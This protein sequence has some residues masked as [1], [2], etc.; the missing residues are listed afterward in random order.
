MVDSLQNYSLL[1]KKQ[2]KTKQKDKKLVVSHVSCFSF[3]SRPGFS[4]RMLLLNE[5]EVS[6]SCLLSNLFRPPAF[7]LEKREATVKKQ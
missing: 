2:N 5:Q 6:T 7:L 4:N 3:F 1:T